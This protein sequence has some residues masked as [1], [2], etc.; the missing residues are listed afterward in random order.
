MQAGVALI[1]IAAWVGV[2]LV[3]LCIAYAI[4]WLLAWVYADF[5]CEGEAYGDV[6][7][8]PLEL[9][10]ARKLE[11]GRS[12]QRGRAGTDGSHSHVERAFIR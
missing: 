8:V 7:M 12:E 1:T 11:G 9:R 2:G 3:M 10:P 6:P 4:A 5:L